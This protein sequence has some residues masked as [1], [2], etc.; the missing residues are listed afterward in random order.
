MK[1]A[2]QS[3]P[4]N[5][6]FACLF[7]PL[8]MA[9]WC[10]C[11]RA[12]SIV[13]D[14]TPRQTRAVNFVYLDST[15]F[16]LND[17]VWF[18]LMLN[19]KVDWRRWGDTVCVSP[20][21]YYDSV[22]AWDANS[23]MQTRE[24]MM[25]HFADIQGLG[26]NALRVC[27]DVVAT[28]GEG[29]YYGSKDA[30]CYLVRDSAAIFSGLRAMLDIADQCG[31]RVMLLLKPPLTPDLTSF[32]EALLHHFANR[33]TVFAYDFMNEPLYFD[34]Q[35]RKDKAEIYTIVD[36]WRQMMNRYAPH[37]LFTIGFAEPIEVFEWDPSILPVDF[38]Q[39][40]T[41]HPL[42]VVNEMYWYGRFSGKPWMVGE[43][44]LPADGD[45]VDY[46]W[47]SRF[48]RETYRA[49]LANGACGYGWWEF[50]D[51]PNGD[52]FDAR[53]GGIYAIKGSKRMAKPVANEVHT[54]QYITTA[55][56]NPN[57]LC[58]YYNM[59]GYNNILITGRVINRKNGR[60]VEGAVIRGWNED[61]SV[62]QNTFTDA[63]GN[64]TLFSNDVCTHF[65]ISG[66][67][68]DRQKFDRSIRLSLSVER[69]DRYTQLSHKQR[70]VYDSLYYHYAIQPK[71]GSTF[72]PFSKLQLP[73]ASLE[74][75]QIPQLS[76][77][78]EGSVLFNYETNDF[79]Q[80]HYQGNMGTVYLESLNVKSNTHSEGK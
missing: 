58:N 14:N 11:G 67:G 55:A 56:L 54:L 5:V 79:I 17:S 66:P 59:L 52:N 19:Y 22:E 49:A 18:P 73:C 78:K 43:T 37:Q 51:C 23:A 28:A 35:T 77:R 61:W 44:A 1:I 29:P 72:I 45:S 80:Y 65:E 24:Q 6:I 39:M 26:F 13:F 68:M 4:R 46:Q 12:S 41:Y 76:L 71:P 15:R 64:F 38:V 42:R 40:H 36:G 25:R 70:Q 63:K 48:L 21:Y 75:Q 50:Q 10:G 8:L 27:I 62:G 30:P 16:M 9:I 74:F 7:A 60:P 33:P 3:T 20:A 69:R 31:L 57:H 34:Q 2:S 32:T 47:Q 53:N